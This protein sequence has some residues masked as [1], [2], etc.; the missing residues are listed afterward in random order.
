MFHEN[1]G[2]HPSDY[3]VT[4]PILKLYF[5][6][7]LYECKGFVSHTERR[8]LYLDIIEINQQRNAG[9]FIITMMMKNLQ[10]P[11]K[12]EIPRKAE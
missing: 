1:T 9:H 3:M 7:V 12:C 8:I 5:L 4:H 6:V 10:F 2:K 11:Q